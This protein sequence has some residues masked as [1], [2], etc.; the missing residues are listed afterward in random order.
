MN[1]TNPK[2]VQAQELLSKAIFREYPGETFP[3]YV[4]EATKLI[5]EAS[6]EDSK[7]QLK[8]MV[9]DQV[10]KL[11]RQLIVDEALRNA[12]LGSEEDF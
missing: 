10:T 9:A 12:F 4:Q 7:E 8:Q 5:Y 2:L 1:N 11:T 6:V 3:E